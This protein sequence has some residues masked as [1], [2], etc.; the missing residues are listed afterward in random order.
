MLSWHSFGANADAV[1]DDGAIA[2]VID[3]DS[4]LEF[5]HSTRLLDSLAKAKRQQAQKFASRDFRAEYDASV[6]QP[7]RELAERFGHLVVGGRPVVVCQRV[8]P[9]IEKNYMTY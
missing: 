8:G 2:A 6:G 7:I 5:T 3:T 4:G 1:D 9:S